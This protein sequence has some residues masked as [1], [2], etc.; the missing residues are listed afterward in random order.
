MEEYSEA[1]IYKSKP[2]LGSYVNA[3]YF[4]SLAEIFESVTLV[5][6]YD[7]Q[8]INRRASADIRTASF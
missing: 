8:R 4:H 1:K 3:D 2:E 6:V 7:K 5:P